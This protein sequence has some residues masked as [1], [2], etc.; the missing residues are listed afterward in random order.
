MSS[1][2]FLFDLG[3]P[4]YYCLY[5]SLPWC[6]M[7]FVFFKLVSFTKFGNFLYI[8]PSSNFFQ[9]FLS[10]SFGT[11]ITYN[12]DSFICSYNSVKARKFWVFFFIFFRI[13]NLYMYW[14]ILSC[15]SKILYFIYDFKL[16]QGIL[17]IRLVYFIGLKFPC[18]FLLI[19]YFFISHL[20]IHFDQLIFEW[21]HI[22]IIATL[23]SL[24]VKSNFW[25]HSELASFFPLICIGV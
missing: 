18:F 13:H 16:M 4:R 8:I 3:A 23:K 10:S 24:L 1:T 17:K 11:Q 6:W 9:S 14:F 12:L 15:T 21:L 20:F 25:A 7:N 19:L 5:I 2:S 22:F